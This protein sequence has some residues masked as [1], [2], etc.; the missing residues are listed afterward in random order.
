MSL[1]KSFVIFLS[2]AYVA[3]LLFQMF[4]PRVPVSSFFE[5]G[6]KVEWPAT[7]DGLESTI[8]LPSWSMAPDFYPLN[9]PI[10]P[11]IQIENPASN[12]AVTKTV[13]LY[14]SKVL[15]SPKGTDVTSG[16]PG[17]LGLTQDELNANEQS[18]NDVQEVPTVYTV[19]DITL[20]PGTSTSVSYT[21]TPPTAG[22]YQVDF[23]TLPP[24][25][26]Y[27]HGYILAAGF[28]RVLPVTTSEAT[29]TPSDP[30]PTATPTPGQSGQTQ[31]ASTS[32]NGNV[33]TGQVA[34]AV[35]TQSVALPKTGK[36]EETHEVGSFMLKKHS[37]LLISELD[38]IKPL[39][40]GSLR[41][42]TFVVGK[43]LVSDINTDTT[44]V[45][46]GHN[47]SDVFGSIHTLTK[48][49]TIKVYEN[50]ETTAYSVT[51]VKRVSYENVKALQSGKDTLLLITCDLT[52]ASVR[53][54]VTAKKI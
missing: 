11:R 19:G 50:G 42:N 18:K 30:Q 25:Q 48:G 47:S 39:Y 44:R 3:F 33:V 53:V 10:T 4:T 21:F 22:Y 17:Q 43:G 26:G 46:Y 32:S 15:E 49:K 20:Q 29:L 24:G 16:Y 36:G 52:D 6:K 54:I 51:S 40:V 31:A 28:I 27:I 5:A 1:K 12:S 9:T 13:Y 7:L 8:D 45:M 23:S 37:Y 34:S 35:L 14:V 38:L 2:S 41:N